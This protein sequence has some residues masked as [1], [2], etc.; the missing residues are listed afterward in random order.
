MTVFPSPFE[1]AEPVIPPKFRQLNRPFVR[2]FGINVAP[3][4][5]TTASH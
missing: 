2:P 4:E 3:Y 5:V 1:T